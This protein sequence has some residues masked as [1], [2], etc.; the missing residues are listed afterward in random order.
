[1]AVGDGNADDGG[2]DV[3]ERRTRFCRLMLAER[4]IIARYL[5]QNDW[6]HA[7]F[8]MLLELYV[9]TGPLS[10]SSLGYAS[11]ASLATAGRLAADLEIRHLITR[12]KDPHD[13]RRTH[14]TMAPRGY[15]AMRCIIDDCGAARGRLQ[16]L[17][18]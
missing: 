7:G 11:G 18:I 12:S 15:A 10:V 14:I 6:N 4:H 13:A 16:P 9:A 5:K 8:I 17:E 2:F 1:M 3:E